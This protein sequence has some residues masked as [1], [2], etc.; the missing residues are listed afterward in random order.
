[1][2]KISVVLAAL[3]LTFGLI[4]CSADK[5]E[6]LT[7]AT[8]AEFEPWEYLD[9]KQNVVGFDAD[10]ITKIA[11]ELK[12]KV[13][14]KNM[15]FESVVAAVAMGNTNVGISGLTINDTRRKSVDFSEPYYEGAAQILIVR[16]DD[17]IFKGKT[18][19]ELDKE[20]VGQTIGVCT[21]FT[22]QAYA[23]GDEEWGFPK[24]EKATVKI[25]E[26]VSLAVMDLK[27]KTINT[28][29][30]DDSVAREVVATPENVGKVKIIDIPLTIESYG[31]AVK[32]GDTEML[33]KVN[34]AL[35]KLIENGYVD[36]LYK[37]WNI[38]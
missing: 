4:G 36:Q 26:N 34:T 3:T 8:N 33:N 24:I 18:K 22:G 17:D 9:D 15:E 28:I 14:F 16:E 32:K 31:I 30:M 25:Y 19:S 29:I 37:K 2:K 20:L 7:V 35:K 38:H 12:M 23:T 21:G 27:S 11:E 6:K 13:E 5:P 1:M 10:L